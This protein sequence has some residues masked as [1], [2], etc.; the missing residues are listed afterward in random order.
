MSFMPLATKAYW[1]T[2]AYVVLLC[3]SQLLSAVIN[4]MN[5]DQHRRIIVILLIVFC[6]MPTFLIGERESVTGWIIN[7]LLFAAYIRKYGLPLDNYKADFGYII[8]SLITGLARVPLGV[9]SNKLME[10]Y[11]LS[12]LF[13]RYNSVTVTAISVFCF[14]FWLLLNVRI[15][16]IALKKIIL[17]VAQLTFSVY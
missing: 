10:S 6:F 5:Q 11:L 12:G 1:F 7:G 8:C 3:M 13:F 16:N 17:K 9:V 4:A 14:G 15:K 2:T